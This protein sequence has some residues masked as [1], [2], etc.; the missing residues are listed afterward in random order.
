[1]CT[2]INVDIRDK[3]QTNAFRL[4]TCSP[5]FMNGD[6]NSRNR[7]YVNS[8]FNAYWAQLVVLRDSLW[9]L[10]SMCYKWLTRTLNLLNNILPWQLQKT[11]NRVQWNVSFVQ[12]AYFNAYWTPLAVLRDSH[13]DLLFKVLSDLAG[14][15][16]EKYMLPRQLKNHGI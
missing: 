14:Y 2:K 13:S 5:I 11:S 9:D 16:T 10:L 3:Q 15:N 1:M 8:Y 4:L 7:Y 6:A 12:I